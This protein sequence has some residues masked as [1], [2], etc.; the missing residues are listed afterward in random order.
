MQYEITETYP[1][2]TPKSNPE[3]AR[4]A[5][6]D[7]LLDHL[8]NQITAGAPYL[9]IAAIRA[10]WIVP[11]QLGYIHTGPIGTVGVIAVDDETAQVV[12]WTPIPQMKTA[13]EELRS[14]RE[15]EL[16]ESFQ[17]FMENRASS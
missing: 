9:M 5:A 14:S 8:G 12:G 11:V 17:S 16:S 13:S 2:N 3:Q 6:P 15:P 7:F 1:T 4:N 10:L